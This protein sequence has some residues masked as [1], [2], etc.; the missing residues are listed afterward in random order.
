MLSSNIPSGFP[1]SIRSGTN[2]PR[3]SWHWR[4]CMP[5]VVAGTQPEDI[6]FL[7][8]KVKE[9]HQCFLKSYAYLWVSL[10]DVHL[11][12]ET[13]STS[14]FWRI[15]LLPS[16][17]TSHRDRGWVEGAILTFHLQ[18]LCPVEQQLFFPGMIFAFFIVTYFK[19]PLNCF[20]WQY[21][22]TLRM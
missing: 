21:A 13:K 14:T 5:R 19:L 18:A 11:I 7:P 20:V 22:Y 9:R 17:H 16:F 10:Q 1:W 4:A 3:M 6:T 8:L 2:P 12:L 15:W